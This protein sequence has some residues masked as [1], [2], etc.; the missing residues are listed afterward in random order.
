M[1]KPK[2]YL[3]LKER[4]KIVLND[5]LESKEKA[6]KNIPE[7]A[8]WIDLMIEHMRLLENE[9]GY[10]QE[11]Y[12]QVITR[13]FGNI[14]KKS[15][16]NS[17]A[18]DEYG[19]AMT[20]HNEKVQV[21]FILAGINFQKWLN[22]GVEERIEAIEYKVSKDK[23]T[24]WQVLQF[25][26]D[27]LLRLSENTPLYGSIRKD[28]IEIQ[29]KKALI[30][31]GGYVI[32][33]EWSGFIF[34]KYHLAFKYLKSV[35]LNGSVEAFDTARNRIKLILDSFSKVPV[36]KEFMARLWRREP[37]VDLFQ[38][39]SS[40]CC[41]A[42]GEKEKYP[43]VHLPGVVCRKYP[44]GILNYLTD[45]GIQVA[46]VYDMSSENKPQ[47]GQCW[48][49]VSL[50]DDGKPILMADSFDLYSKYRASESQLAGI[51]KCMF[52]FLK[53]YAAQC[54]ISKI[55]LGKDG[56]LVRIKKDHHRMHE[57]HNDVPVADLMMVNFRM[58]IEKLGGFFLGRPYF[59]ETRGGMNAY[60]VAENL[61]IPPS[62]KLGVEEA[63]GMLALMQILRMYKV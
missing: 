33:Q 41:I 21:E 19:W 34:P 13:T 51:R 62:E 23:D 50:D 38:G 30:F 16:S 12:L 17:S 8:Y 32:P 26:F 40:D 47:I 25:D 14:F 42:I 5:L 58:P 22:Y 20:Q 46:E 36:K 27:C 35:K 28:C 52:N 56:P 59:L 53:K 3:S 15:L 29:K 48:L 11:L 24:R 7:D 6:V 4:K 2:K 55:V 10:I 57:I 45:L 44:A 54:G 9:P 61:P 39:N 1:G 18:D 43:A 49:Y 31:S 63:E 37:E 60:L